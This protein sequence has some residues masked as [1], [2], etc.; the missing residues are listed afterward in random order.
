MTIPK[1]SQ[2]LIGLKAIYLSLVSSSFAELLPECT[3]ARSSA[4][5]PL[6]C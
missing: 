3:D 5:K 1:A 6:D 4:P 2:L